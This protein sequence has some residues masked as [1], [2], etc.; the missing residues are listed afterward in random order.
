MNQNFFS[1]RQIEVP[2]SVQIV[3]V[4]DMFVDDYVG[5][6]E[7]TTEA[8]IKTSPLTVMKVRSKDVDMDL[9]QRGH[10]KFWIFGNFAGID[11]NLIP[12]IVANM[13]YSVLEY[14]YK[15]CRYR[16]AEKHQA[17]E[18]TPC[19]CASEWNGQVISVFLHGAKS[20]W[21]M[22]ERQKAKYVKEFPTL[23]NIK[24][25]VLSSVFDDETLVRIADLREKYRTI[26]RKGWIVLGSQSWVKG[27]QAAEEWCKQNNKQY[28]TVWNVP[29]GELLEKL[30]AAEGFVYLPAGGDT[31][32]RM[33]I[34][35]KLLGCKLHLNENV[36]HATEEWFDTDDALLTESYLYAARNVFWNG[37]RSDM[38]ST[39]TIS[40]YTTTY[41]CIR[42]DYPFEAS[43]RSMLGFCD[44]VI[45]VDGGS[46][47]GTWEKLQTMAV[48]DNRLI[49]HQE[50]R[51][52]NTK[53]FA[54]FDG[55]QKA[56]ARSL[57]SG[58]F[59]WQQDSDEIVHENDYAK[60]R[61]VANNFPK[62]VDLI[63][64][65][66]IEYWGGPEKVRL[67]VT[68]WKWR[69]SRNAPHITHGIPAQL[70]RFDDEGRL[71][72]DR[73]SDGCD[74][75]RSDN[76][77]V[78]PF[79]G[80]MSQDAE[81]ARQHVLATR[82]EPVKQEYQRWFKSVIDAI[83]SVHHYSW[84]D[85]ERK[86]RTYRDYWTKHWLSLYNVRQDDTA[87]NNM[88]FDRP[89]SQVDETEIS[90]LAIRLANETG[91]WIFHR[92][93]D[94]THSTPHLTIDRSHPIEVMGWVQKKVKT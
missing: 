45:V 94:L 90:A 70:R 50:K 85:M 88:F 32:P 3:F 56:L 5:G 13:Q 16:S 11:K 12:T 26:E 25:T 48:S 71:Y 7:L 2:D 23:A 65:P 87:E 64:L 44:E 42:Q 40:G 53:R 76:F 69:F 61:N 82:D 57:C 43:I 9:L 83:P 4:A 52:W 62:D 92:K 24:N 51:D 75:V 59:C 36:E 47:D 15:Y 68:P 10:N 22:S 31:C 14:D 20:I 63:A 38:P 21:W 78:V 17:C 67:D 74:Y 29:Y 49:V 46:D 28:E 72:S 6:A 86:I 37:I 81:A 19:N 60:V 34:E 54:V 73:G 80:F 93:L 35:A 66:V 79:A 8:L 18:M 58:N 27:W 41:N 33:V 84:F 1:V 30:A 89:W 77:T 55:Q 39:A 91:G